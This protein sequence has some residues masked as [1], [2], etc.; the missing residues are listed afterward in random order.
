MAGIRGWRRGRWGWWGGG[1]PADRI[2]LLT[3]PRPVEIEKGKEGGRGG[4]REDWFNEDSCR[5]SSSAYGAALWISL[6]DRWAEELISGDSLQRPAQTQRLCF[7]WGEVHNQGYQRR[8][9]V[10]G[11]YYQWEK[12]LQLEAQM[13]RGIQSKLEFDLNW[14]QRRGHKLQ[15]Q[16]AHAYYLLDWHAWNRGLRN[17][18]LKDLL[19]LPN[20]RLF[21]VLAL[22]LP[23]VLLR[24]V[25]LSALAL[26]GIHL[27]HEW[28]RP[29][30]PTLHC[31]SYFHRLLFQPGTASP[32]ILSSPQ[33]QYLPALLISSQ[34]LRWWINHNE[35]H[36]HVLKPGGGQFIWCIFG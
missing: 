28:Q 21:G 32:T 35:A 17:Q 7:S 15:N 24:A 14:Q 8:W 16:T 19:R 34:T 23:V 31:H 5:E 18:S 9:N 25:P 30:T 3:F 4:G 1:L 27:S 26:C 2:F 29:P 33:A 11:I 10:T 22:C 36:T 20:L 13:R 6:A 12:A